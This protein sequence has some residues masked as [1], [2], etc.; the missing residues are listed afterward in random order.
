MISSPWAHSA[1]QTVPIASIIRRRDL[2]PRGAPGRGHMRTAEPTKVSK[3]KILPGTVT[4][5]ATRLR[6]GEVP[7][8]VLLARRRGQ[9][10]LVDGFH[11]VEAALACGHSD[12]LAKIAP[13]DSLAEIRWQ[14]VAA[15]AD[16]GLP[17]APS[18]KKHM[19]KTYIQ[20][21]RHKLP[22]GSLR[23]YRQIAEDLFG[24]VS[25]TTAH[26][27]MTELFPEVAEE[28]AM[29]HS[30]PSG[31]EH[32]DWPIP[33]QPIGAFQPGQLLTEAREFAEGVLAG[34]ADR[35]KLAAVLRTVAK[36]LDHADES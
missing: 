32:S 6:N 13:I 28:M 36:E 26:R 8:P 12:I 35:N 30:A 24:Y 27:F 29:A 33:P 7:P 21:G 17:L 22:D 18:V 31:P 5:Y 16:H 20:T 3:G 2:Q 25:T 9:L 14:A 23:S 34:G 10:L 4:R 19:F 11:R 15:N 1:A